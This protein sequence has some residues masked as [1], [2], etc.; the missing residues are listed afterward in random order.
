MEMGARR[1]A[2]QRAHDLRER[3]AVTTDGKR[4]TVLAN[5]ASPEELE[6]GLRTGA[7][8]IGLLRT[9][10]AFLESTDWPTEQQHSEAL[11]PILAG[12]E[13]Q[14]A[15]V[16]VLDF[17]ADKSPP[18]LHDVA[19]RGIELLLAYPGAFTAQ[20]R[21]IVL[22]SRDHDIRVLLPMV[23]QPEQLAESRS[24]IE[25]TAA[26]LGVDRV[27]P[28]GSMIETPTAAQNAP[29]IAKHSDFL[30]VGTNDL[31]ASTLG[32]DRFVANTA[33][34]HHPLVL[35]SI[36]ASVVAAHEVGIPIEVCGE[37]ASDPIMLPLLVGLG[38]DQVSVG[39][40]RVGT[41]REWIRQLDAEGTAELARSALAMDA[42]E[43]VE[44]AV[45]PLAVEHALT[46]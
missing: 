26:Q 11:K 1:A 15:I 33:R 21:A 19:Q 35:R 5:V 16:R 41:V 4:I 36:A 13:N 23:D 39:A 30:S 34:A 27:P 17:G 2:A 14:P 18:F 3:P 28:L 44:W 42:A 12:L 45:R 31:T 10:L 22:A 7:E 46:S 37:A 20:L 40:A 43:E 25:Q 6:L 8:G 38:I 29:A 9:E 24:L 32:L